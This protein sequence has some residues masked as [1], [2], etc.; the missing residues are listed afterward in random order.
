M[1]AEVAECH[2]Q[3]K[4]DKNRK[5]LPR[6]LFCFYKHEIE[7]GSISRWE[8]PRSLCCGLEEGRPERLPGEEYPYWPLCEGE[9]SFYC[10]NPLGFEVARYN[11]WPIVINAGWEARVPGSFGGTAKLQPT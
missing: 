6:A 2:F 8:K 7:V 3:A 1:S 9:I 5:C 11:G 4:K 10:V